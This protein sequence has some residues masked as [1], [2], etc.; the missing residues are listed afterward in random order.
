MGHSAFRAKRSAQASFFRLK[1]WSDGCKT[2][3]KILRQDSWSAGSYFR[4][5]IPRGTVDH[6][7]GPPL[8]F[9]GSAYAS[10]AHCGA[11]PQC[12]GIEDR[13]AI[14]GHGRIRIVPNLNEPAISEIA[15]AHF[16]MAIIVGRITRIDHNM[17]VVIGRTRIIA[18]DIS[19]GHLMKWII[20]SQRQRGIV[21]KNLADP[22]NASGCPTIT[23]V[24]SQTRLVLTGD[25][26]SPGQ[27][28]PGL[29]KHE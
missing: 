16:F 26:T 21:G 14:A 1:L 28:E 8:R 25:P 27:T 5:G 7:Q 19:I 11:S 10:R 3:P 22:K 9:L 20:C 15:A 2:S 23:L 6:D 12:C 4:Q 13:T 24:F 18:P 29:R 17:P